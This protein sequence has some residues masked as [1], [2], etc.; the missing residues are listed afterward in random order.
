M[1]VL[2]TAVAV[3]IFVAGIVDTVTGYESIPRGAPVVV[4]LEAGDYTLYWE[5]RPGRDAGVPSG[6]QIIDPNGIPVPTSPYESEEVL[7]RG[8]FDAF[9]VATFTAPVDGDYTII[10]PLADLGVSKGLFDQ[11]GKSFLLSFAIGTAGL[12]VGLGIFLFVFLRRRSARMATDPA[13]ATCGGPAP[14]GYGGPAPTGYGGGQAPTAYG[15]GQAPRRDAPGFEPEW[16]AAGRGPEAG[17]GEG[18]GEAGTLPP[19]GWYPD[20]EADG[21]RYWDGRQWTEHRAVRG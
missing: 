12:F 16:G 3:A 10:S 21:L 17:H 15:G 20:P 11:I 8:D 1:V 18:A 6:Y 2:A 7:S 4:D 19:P 13:S 14:T 5:Q 9:A